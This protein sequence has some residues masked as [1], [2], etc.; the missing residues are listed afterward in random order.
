MDSTSTAPVLNYSSEILREKISER[1]FQEQLLAFLK[2][3]LQKNGIP[4][5]GHRDELAQEIASATNVRTLEKS[6]KFDPEKGNAKTWIFTI[7]MNVAREI[8][9]SNKRFPR[10]LPAK[11]ED[12]PKRVMKL[13][14]EIASFRWETIKEAITQL[15]ADEQKLYSL[16]F[17][18]SKSTEQI[19]V[20]LG[21]HSPAIRTRISRLKKKLSQL[22]HTSET[23]VSDE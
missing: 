15:S 8:L 23:E 3:L 16:R 1:E 7:A 18:Q 21:V 10:S 2:V 19:G 12:I 22:T 5:G 11:P 6:N 13:E 17:E 14:A 20:I 4:Q 9:R